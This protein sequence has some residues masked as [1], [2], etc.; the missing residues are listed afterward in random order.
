MA[1]KP[2]QVIPKDLEFLLPDKVCK[3]II[4]GDTA[5]DLFPLTEG[6][7]EVL[8]MEV[9]KLFDAVFVKAEMSP[10]DYLMNKN[11]LSTILSEALKPLST[12]HI[13]TNLT[14]KQ[15][16]YAASVLWEMNF[17]SADFDEDTKANFKKV[18]GWI[19][20]GAMSPAAAPAAPEKEK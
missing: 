20:L 18:L 9:S 1:V 12:E 16:M 2:R 13:K 10:I 11:V 19:G 8:S 6:E 5:Y 4:I 14:A 7:F 3:P 17:E 15:M